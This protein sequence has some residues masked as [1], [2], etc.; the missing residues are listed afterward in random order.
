LKSDVPV[1]VIDGGLKFQLTPLGRPVC[2]SVTGELNPPVVVTVTTA[3]PVVPRFMD[4]ELGETER[5]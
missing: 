2:E 3:N 4:P 5:L 1:P